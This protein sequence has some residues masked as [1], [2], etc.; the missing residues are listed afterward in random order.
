MVHRTKVTFS[1]DLQK[2]LGEVL[3]VAEQ[4][5]NTRVANNRSADKLTKTKDWINFGTS[6]HN[7]LCLHLEPV[8][9]VLVEH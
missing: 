4:S 7:N 8:K 5:I 9:L 2:T 3:L 1:Q 6:S